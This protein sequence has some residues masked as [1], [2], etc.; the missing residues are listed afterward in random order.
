M[1]LVDDERSGGNT[2]TFMILVVR[3]GIDDRCRC[4]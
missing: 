4:T 1:A 2:L 3:K